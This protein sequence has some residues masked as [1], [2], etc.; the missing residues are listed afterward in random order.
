MELED[1]KKTI[2]AAGGD[3]LYNP[4]GEPCGCGI[5]HLA[6]CYDCAENVGECVVGFLHQ[7]GLFYPE[8][9][10][11]QHGEDTGADL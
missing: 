11:K 1:I 10:E 6:P 9:P 5:D 7:D 4:E 2:K 8:P 3:G